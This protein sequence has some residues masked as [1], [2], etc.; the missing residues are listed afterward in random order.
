M[1][2]PVR[3]NINFQQ[4]IDALLNET[5]P[6]PPV[7]LHSF[8]DIN[9]RELSALKHI[10][11]EVS[12]KRRQALLEDLEE[13]AEVDTLVSFEDVAKMALKDE[14]PKVRSSAIR[15]LWE[16]QDK[17]LI[18]V[19]INLM[20]NDPEVE[21][22][23]T[24]ST[25]LGVFVYLGE[26]EEI[27]PSMLTNIE[28]SLL[29]VT[30]GKDEVLVRRR[31]LESLG[32][33]SRAEVP[34]LLRSAFENSQAEWKE[35]ALFAMGRSADQSW[36]KSVLSELNNSN[37]SIRAEAIQ[38]AG[39]L[40]LASARYPLLQILSD[41]LESD[42]VW[43]ATVWS[44]SQ[45]GGEAVRSTLEHL[46]EET[47]DPDEV[48][49]LEEALDNLSF[50]EDMALFNMLEVDPDQSETHIVDMDGLQLVI[51]DIHNGKLKFFYWFR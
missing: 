23:A 26:I 15:L 20:K 29:A 25:G 39:E 5:R 50:T 31:A 8:S 45:I 16:I 10:W 46:I 14:N 4:V 40:E 13:L 34:D 1:N 28:D 33:S 9:P 51:K 32:F 18:P 7:Y 47:E 11:P 42:E 35:S 6:F 48:D 3:R 36:E 30:Q 37:D 27:P 17:K 2:E 44:L 22:R 12:A 21:V 43:A 19:F 38:A 49:F 24:A 41:D